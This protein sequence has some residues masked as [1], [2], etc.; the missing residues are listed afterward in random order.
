MQ[1]AVRMESKSAQPYSPAGKVLPTEEASDCMH[2][3]VQML[4][5]ASPTAPSSGPSEQDTHRGI[6][7]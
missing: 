3:L 5:A 6:R 2:V 1:T 7:P 4:S